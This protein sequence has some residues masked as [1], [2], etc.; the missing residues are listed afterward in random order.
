ME[1]RLHRPLIERDCRLVLCSQRP[2]L[3]MMLADPSDRLVGSIHT[4]WDRHVFLVGQRRLTRQQMR[5]GPIHQINPHLADEDQRSFVDVPDLQELPDH[6]EFEHGADA[7]GS[8]HEGIRSQDE[9]VQ[10][11]EK[12]LVLEHLFY[13]RIN[14][15]LERQV[16]ANPDG[17]IALW[18]LGRSRSFVGGLHE[19]RAAALIMSQS[20]SANAVATRL[21][22]S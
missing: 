17:A 15:L 16:H 14:L 4:P 3:V 22:S 1:T 7:P 21:T 20:I 10:P 13:K 5:P 9:V 11:R 12:S 8:Y 19:T 6:H 18:S 2:P